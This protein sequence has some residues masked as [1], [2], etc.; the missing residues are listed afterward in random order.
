MAVTFE[1][2]VVRDDTHSPGEWLVLPTAALPGDVDLI[3]ARPGYFYD[4]RPIQSYSLSASTPGTVV[5]IDAFGNLSVLP[6]LKGVQYL[7]AAPIIGQA[8]SCGD[9]TVLW[10]EQEPEFRATHIPD[11]AC[12][13]DAAKVTADAA[14][15]ISLWDD[16]ST[17]TDNSPAQAIVA[18]QPVL[19]PSHRK[20][21]GL[22]AVEFNSAKFLQW[23]GFAN[24]TSQVHIFMAL[25]LDKSPPQLA[26]ESGL[27]HLNNSTNSDNYPQV[28]SAAQGN[29]QEILLGAGSTQRPEITTL[30]HLGSPDTISL[31]KAHILEVVATT[32]NWIM[33]LNGKEIHSRPT[34]NVFDWN[35]AGK[36]GESQS[37]LFRLKGM[38][39]AFIVYERQ[40]TNTEASVV[41]CG[42]ADRFKIEGV[43]R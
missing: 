8:T 29:K 15:N 19:I 4:H 25:A 24:A 21:N 9:L 2:R 32:R 16:M 6:V 30:Q 1:K 38:V 42:L 20:F 35:P 23:A 11:C 3:S 5:L 43:E 40:L 7:V 22:A 28:E 31:E 26:V 10:R 34:G 14:G 37:P 18:N 33:Y 41:R 27:W 36:L 17:A 12:W 13:L 39:G